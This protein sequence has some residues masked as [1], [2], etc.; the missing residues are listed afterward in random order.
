MG[1]GASRRARAGRV[2]RAALSVSC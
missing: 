2:R 1:K